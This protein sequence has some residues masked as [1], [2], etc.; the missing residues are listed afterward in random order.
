MSGFNT[1][2]L[3]ILIVKTLLKK[4][5]SPR[6]LPERMPKFLFVKRDLKLS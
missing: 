1:Y 2:L 5:K 3:I 4:D 6:G